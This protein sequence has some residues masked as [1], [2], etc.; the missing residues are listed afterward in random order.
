[1]RKLK[2]N[3]SQKVIKDVQAY[4]KKVP[5]G[6]FLL[7]LN[8]ILLIAQGADCSDVAKLFQK[9]IRTIHLWVNTVNNDNINALE[10][11]RRPG[12]TSK[13]T[14]SVREQLEQDL[15]FSPEIYGYNQIA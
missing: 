4:F 14:D 7:R 3:N 15:R 6:D 8:A 1:M 13:L 9:S 2:I 12:R 10:T 11:S 5:E